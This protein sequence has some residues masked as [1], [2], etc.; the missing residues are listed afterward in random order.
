MIK[1]MST[2]DFFV[3][4]IFWNL[5]LLMIPFF[6]W[7]TLFKL[8]KKNKY[9]SLGAKIAAGALFFLWFLFLP[10]TVYL[11]VDTR[12]LF[13]GCFPNEHQVC[14]GSVWTVFFLFF[15]ACL[16]W[17]AFVFLV[18]RMKIFAEEV[19]GKKAA[20][21]FV[22]G[23]MPLISLGVLL[24]LV[25]RW[26]SWDFFFS[27]GKIIF[28]AWAQVAEAGLFLDWF[29]TLMILYALYFGG[30]YLFKD[31]FNSLISKYRV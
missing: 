3:F 14:A 22:I 24:G 26:N 17:T 4:D 2:D 1:L 16:G 6:V 5:F 25:E 8:W 28:D 19:I 15:Y 9:R 31:R 21:F 7:L 20:G 29:L 10:N 12:H 18:S 11:I 23:I 13:S 30:N 27:P